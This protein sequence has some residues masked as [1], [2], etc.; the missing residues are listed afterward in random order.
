MF[1]KHM[2]TVRAQSKEDLLL[3]SII[4]IIVLLS[5][6]Y[7]LGLLAGTLIANLI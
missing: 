4:I 2:C 5:A 6:V 3:G 7:R 1:E